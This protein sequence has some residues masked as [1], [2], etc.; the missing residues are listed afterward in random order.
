MNDNSTVY[1]Q[2]YDQGHFNGRVPGVGEYTE[3]SVSNPSADYSAADRVDIG[4][5]EG[6]PIEFQYMDGLISRCIIWSSIPA[7]ANRWLASK[8]GSGFA[9]EKLI[10]D[11]IWAYYPMNESSASADLDAK[12]GGASKDL[13]VVSAPG[14]SDDGPVIYYPRGGM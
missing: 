2:T 5:R 12:I 4:R 1:A 6:S 10:P 14:V 7:R 3:N 13:T 8:L 11:S 9:P